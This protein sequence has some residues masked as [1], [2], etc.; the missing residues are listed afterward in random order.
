MALRRTPEPR[1]T[2]RMGFRHDWEPR[3]GRPLVAFDSCRCAACRVRVGI[4]ASDI[5]R[6][7]YEAAVALNPRRPGEGPMAYI[8][9]ISGIVTDEQRVGR[10]VPE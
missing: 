7:T 5:E 8:R 10:P 6:Q 3:D 1:D 9:R 4:W 2:G